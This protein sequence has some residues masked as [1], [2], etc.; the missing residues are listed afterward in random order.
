MTTSWRVRRQTL[1]FY[2]TDATALDALVPPRLTIQEL[3][4]GIGLCSIETLEYMPGHFGDTTSSFE[5][6]FSVAVQPNLSIAMPV[7]KLSLFIVS[8]LSS[9]AAFVKEEAVLLRM[10]MEHVPQ[11]HMAFGPPDGASVHVSDGETP[12]VTCTNTLP[13]QTYVEQTHHGL[14]YTLKD[15]ELHQGAFRWHGEVCE[16]QRGGD[17]GRFYPHPILRGMPPKAVRGCYRQ[18]TSNP[19]VTARIAYYHLGVLA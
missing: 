1:A 19:A 18:M 5:L 2:E 4:P 15:G 11:L 17:W 14:V 6:V 12:I 13:D 9:S 7:P 16:H 8:V 10:P 3:R